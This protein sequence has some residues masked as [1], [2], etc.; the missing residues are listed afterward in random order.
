M[1][2]DR[3]DP[4]KKSLP[5]AS[6]DNPNNGAVAVEI[7]GQSVV[8]TEAQHWVEDGEHV[9]VSVEF[10]VSSSGDSFLE[11]FE[12]IIDNLFEETRSL[13]ARIRDNDAAPNELDEALRLAE[14]FTQIAELEE[15]RLRELEA[16]RIA[17][18][19]RRL[20]RGNRW[21]SPRSVRRTSGTP[22]V[23]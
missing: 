5:E 20:N 17:G 8:L 2:K 3:I 4:R 19:R 15:R 6:P 13:N 12:Q 23:A 1:G 10:Q 14:R 9:I 22:S 11:A 21:V 16:A 18:R 7:D